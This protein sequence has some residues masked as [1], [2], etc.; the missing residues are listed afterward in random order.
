MR[1]FQARRLRRKNWVY[2]GRIG[3]YLSR[4]TKGS[5]TGNDTFLVNGTSHDFTCQ[6]FLTR[7][8]KIRCVLVEKYINE[9]YGYMCAE[10]V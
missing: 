1:F 3:P 7:N 2:L 4:K 10:F 6:L 8:L 5:A 9:V